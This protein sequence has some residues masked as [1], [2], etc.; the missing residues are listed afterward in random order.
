MSYYEIT[1]R[2]AL[3]R[4]KNDDAIYLMERAVEA[5][6][7]RLCVLAVD[8]ETG[9][10]T[11]QEAFEI[12]IDGGAKDRPYTHKEERIS[13]RKIG[14]RSTPVPMSMDHKIT[15]TADERNDEGKVIE[16]GVHING[17]FMGQLT[18]WQW[19]SGAWHWDYIGSC[20]PDDPSSWGSLGIEIPE[21]ATVTKAKADVVDGILYLGPD[22]DPLAEAIAAYQAD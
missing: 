3:F 15:F 13:N 10:K 8:V 17:H 7:L 2:N 22:L 21:G 14:R 12:L 11:I 1:F 19:T 4:L 5:D 16:Y 9:L 6:N 20:D 18:R